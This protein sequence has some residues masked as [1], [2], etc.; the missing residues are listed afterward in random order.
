MNSLPYL[1]LPAGL[2]PRSDDGKF[3]YDLILLNIKVDQLLGGV[4]YKGV[5]IGP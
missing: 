5:V 1:R 4:V 2:F 3:F